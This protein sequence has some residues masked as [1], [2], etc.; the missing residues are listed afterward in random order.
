M[1]PVVVVVLVMDGVDGSKMLF[2]LSEGEEEDEGQRMREE[3]K[4]ARA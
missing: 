2:L 1:L 3:L 4:A